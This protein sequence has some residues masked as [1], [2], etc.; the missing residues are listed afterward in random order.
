MMNYTTKSIFLGLTFM[1][2]GCDLSETNQTAPQPEEQRISLSGAFA[3]YPLA[4]KWS[5]E[6]MK[7]HPEVKFDI[8]AGGAGKGLADALSGTVDLGMFS[9]SITQ[10]EK[11]K[12]VW[13]VAVAKDAVLP[14]VS[15]T[16]PDI[17]K[18]KAQGLTQAH[19]KSIFIDKA[20]VRWKDLVKGGTNESVNPYTRSDACGAAGTWAEYLGGSQEN[21]KG[22]GV[23]GDP[24]LAEAVTRDKFGIGYNN[25]VFVY[26]IATGA[27]VPGIE[28]VPIDI[29][30]NGTIDST[31]QLYANM[32]TILEAI[33][34][35]R[36]PSPPA[37]DLYFVAKGSPQEAHVAEFI[38]WT[39]NE[40]QKF[41]T[42]AGYVMLKEDLISQEKAKLQ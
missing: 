18:I 27:K 17:A 29:N 1:M 24:G 21:L 14:T 2:L 33:A 12:G 31:E 6:Y 30:E 3:L 9:R 37:R 26:D 32:P 22:T 38:K 10:A 40:G 8:Q 7:L 36:Y 25:T 42:E 13:W 41:V 16:H 19:F 23:F 4:I 28:V 15:S 39:L 5:E 34:D 35:G 11:D 20:K